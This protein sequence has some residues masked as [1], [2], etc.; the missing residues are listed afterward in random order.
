MTVEKLDLSSPDLVQGNIEKIQVLF[1]NVV[2][3]GPDGLSID[4]DALRQELSDTIVEGPQERYRLDWP[5]KRSAMLAA[6]MPISKT[7]RPV[8]EE[9]VDFDT[10][11]NLF[12]EGDNLDALKL[13]QYSYSNKV[14]MIYIDPPYNTG[15]DFIYKDNFTKD[16]SDYLEESGQV[17][18]DGGRLVANPESNGRYHSDWLSMMYP[19]LKLAR[20]LLRDDGIF[21]ASIDNNEISNLINLLSEV[22]GGSNIVGVVANVNNPK[23]RSD[24]KYFATS[25]EYL[26][27]VAKNE[28]TLRTYGFEP[29]ER[30][31]KRYNKFDKNN[32]KYREMDL[33]KTGDSDRRE[34]RPD[35]FY[36]F[37]HN[38]VDNSLSVSKTRI[39]NSTLTEIIPLR[40]DNTHGRWRWG[41]D[42]ASKRLNDVFAKLMPVRKIWTIVE[43]DYLEGRPPVKPTTSWT[44]KDVN[45]ERGS[46]AFVRLGFDKEVFSRPKPVGTMTRIIEVATLP[47]EKSVIMDLFAGSATISEAAFKLLSTKK[48]FVQVISMQ[49]PEKIDPEKKEDK[50][51][52]DFCEK[53]NL[54]P[55]ISEIS[56][57][58][59]RRAGAK[60]LDENPD[61]V[62]KLDV[63]FRVLKI[64]SSN[65]KDVHSDPRAL[66]QGELLDAISHIKPDRSG[67]DLLFQVMLNQ[68]IELSQSIIRETIL[69]YTVYFVG[70]D[71]I[72]AC[73]DSNIPDEL[74]K[75]L[76]ERNPLHVIFKDESF[77]ESD[78]K[79]N[80][81]QLLKQISKAPTHM[82]VI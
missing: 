2:T 41:F 72:V 27:G 78:D 5:G 59:I 6:N 7:L 16:K 37:Y 67:E 29:E 1:P 12:I 23:G 34:D 9:S 26:V 11:Q 68:G 17:D 73:F 32:K 18:E 48:R 49:F 19:R 36:Y 25:H 51:G 64:D 24:D 53:N 3:E 38:K 39:S 8:R 33:R 77:K 54:L 44:F 62:G 65:M 82:K 69:G 79:I 60:I 42:T 4:F 66:K 15:K 47:E 46:E 57:E 71:N 74:V 10:T 31:T 76:A 61:Q 55:V 81:A 13:L 58:R 80:A 14:K 70:Q 20:N 75:A 63:G 21:I 50:F 45:S 28:S 22:F 52:Y 56:K 35:M 40:D 43:K 30:I